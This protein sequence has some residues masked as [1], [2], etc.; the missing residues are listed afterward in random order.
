MT[1]DS[2]P[3]LGATIRLSVYWEKKPDRLGALL[4]APV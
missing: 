2:K 4:I 1:I 3:G